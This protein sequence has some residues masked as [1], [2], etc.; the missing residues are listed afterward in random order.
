MK[1]ILTIAIAAIL[2]I[3][4][5]IG[6]VSCGEAEKSYNLGLGVV[7]STASSKTGVAQVDATFAAVVLDKDGKIVDCKLDV[8]QN[9]CTVTDGT[10]P[11][12]T[13]TFE[14]KGEKKEKYG[15]KDNSSIKKEWYEQ[16]EAFAEFVI[17]MTSTE[18]AGITTTVN[19]AG[20]KVAT[21]ETL[22]AGCTID[23]S[24]FIKAVTKACEDAKN[25]TFKA[26]EYKL[27][28]AANTTLDSSSTSATEEA[29]GSANMYT[30]FSATAVDKDG[31]VLVAI[32]DMIQPKIKFNTA[33]EITSDTTAEVLTKRERGDDYGMKD[34]SSI[35]K[36]WYE[37]AAAFENYIKGK[38]ATEVL[39]I[40]TTTNDAGHKVPADET[41]AASC[42]IS[43]SEFQ[44]VVAKAIG[45]A[46]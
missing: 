1:K 4:G 18:V 42:T 14:T 22:L 31:K 25:Y 20:H 33:G 9:K 5:V 32:V 23:I 28:I 26:S 30:N 8:A 37:Q 13:L 3:T 12:E 21:N 7:V 40:V 35:K 10:L 24:D 15:M 41:L 44:A 39:S 46:K 29:D 36:E 43:I 27:G 11:A 38:T 2:A 17:G 16:A 19:D 34:S 45:N 6:L